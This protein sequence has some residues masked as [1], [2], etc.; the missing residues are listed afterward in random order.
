MKEKRTCEKKI[1]FTATE[2]KSVKKL[3]EEFG[4]TNESAFMRDCIL[5]VK[6]RNT[7]N[8]KKRIQVCNELQELV[9]IYPDDSRVK[10][11]TEN[12]YNL[13]MKG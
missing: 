9:K 2:D 10:E 5:N 7:L 13:L 6:K 3:K 8:L 4:F 12:V 1:K 11:A